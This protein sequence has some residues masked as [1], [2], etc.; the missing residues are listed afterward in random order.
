MCCDVV[1]GGLGGDHEPVGDL[2]GRQAEGEQPEHLGLAGG[3]PA[4]QGVGGRR[5]GDRRRRAPARPL[6]RRG[7]PAAAHRSELGGGGVAGERGAVRTIGGHRLVAVGG[8][9]HTL[10]VVEV[11]A[12]RHGGGSRTRRRARAPRRRRRRS[13]A[14][15]GRRRRSWSVTS[16]CISARSRSSRVSAPGLSH[17]VFGTAT[18]PRSCTSAAASA[19]GPACVAG[20]LRRPRASGRRAT[21]TS[22]RRSRRA[23]AATRAPA[24]SLERRATLARRRARRPTDRPARPSSHH[25]GAVGEH[26]VGELRVVGLAPPAADDRRAPGRCPRCGRAPRAPG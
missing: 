16:A 22:G 21:A 11:R 23:R 9:E 5:G 25:S 26:E 15:Y 17:T 3:E 1:V 10:R 20:E 12:G 6:R 2:P 4:G 24:A 18:R 8:G 19:I 7:V 14:V 13:A